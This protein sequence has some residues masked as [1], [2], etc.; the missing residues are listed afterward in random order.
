MKRTSLQPLTP[1]PN[2]AGESKTGVAEND[3]TSD[4]E[5]EVGSGKTK[6]K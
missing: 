5:F 3:F 2:I 1:D 6:E 4:E